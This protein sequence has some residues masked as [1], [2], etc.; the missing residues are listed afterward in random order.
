MSESRLI[1]ITS[2]ICKFDEP[3]WVM[4]Y[5]MSLNESD[6]YLLFRNFVSSS[7]KDMNIYDA[8]VS[9]SRKYLIK[10]GIQ[11]ESPVL[12]VVNEQKNNDDGMSYFDR[13]M[14]N[15]SSM[16]KVENVRGR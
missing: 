2:E 10:K 6:I 1:E 7:Y 15:D 12:E 16:R 8:L 11:I 14:E 4:G 13:M 3:L 9:F 5:V